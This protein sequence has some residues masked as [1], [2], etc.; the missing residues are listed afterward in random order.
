MTVGLVVVSHSADL[1]AGVRE[2]AAQMAPDVAIQV[3]GGTDDG[4]VGTSFDLV[5]AALEGADSGT[6]VVVLYDLGSALLTTETAVE[7]ADPAAAERIV[8]VDAPLVEGAV[9]AAVAAQSGADLTA[10]ADAA[11]RA[12]DSWPPPAGLGAAPPASPDAH[13]AGAADADADADADGDAADDAACTV[14]ATV[15]DPDGIHARPASVLGR[16]AGRWPRAAI[17]I[18]RPGDAAVALADVLQVIGLG[19]RQGEAVVLTGAGPGAEQAAAALG[20][21]ID[22]G[23]DRPA[24]AVAQN[25]VVPSS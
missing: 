5:S 3:A 6:G 14:T 10:V 22:A 13:A 16:A 12:G 8:V 20:A 24:A 7:F 18:G 25:P 21:M 4:G 1:A 2:L 17:R 15:A 9:A 23:L 19:L 11:R